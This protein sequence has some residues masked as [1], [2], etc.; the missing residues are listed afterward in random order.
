MQFISFA[1]RVLCY[2][3]LMRKLLLVPVI[4]ALLFSSV[5]EAANTGTVQTATTAGSGI[6]T[7]VS[8][9]SSPSGVVTDGT[10]IYW[11]NQASD[12][13]GRANLDGTGQNATW[14]TG[15][16]SG[17]SSL[18]TDGS[19]LY[20]VNRGS[21]NISRAAL[22]GSGLQANFISSGRGPI[23]LT[24]NS[25]HIY[26][27]RIDSRTSTAVG[28]ANLDG[29]G[30]VQSW[31]EPDGSTPISDKF[32]WAGIAAT[33]TYI[34]IGMSGRINRVAISD[35]TANY[36]F[37]TTSGYVRSVDIDSGQIYWA[38]GETG[39]IGKASQDGTGASAIVQTEPQLSGLDVYSGNIYWTSSA[40]PQYTLDIERSGPGVIAIPGGNIY[41]GTECRTSFLQGQSFSLVALPAAG[42]VFNGYSG[43]CSGISCSLT[44]GT[45]NIDIGSS[46]SYIP[47]IWKQRPAKK[48]PSPF[49][50]FRYEA[51]GADSYSCTLDRKTVPCSDRFTSG[52]LSAGRH[53]FTA[54]AIYSNQGADKKSWTWRVLKAENPDVP[55][56]TG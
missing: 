28:R 37:I 56:F 40:E 54:Q 14:L 24:I 45:S 11:S 16:F 39:I 5:A 50:T 30:A 36:G 7:L 6:S 33:D 21:W 17:P 43:A 23:S 32:G 9:Q 41:C 48:S 18:I 25:T 10:Y 8:G 46:F 26:W 3:T 1:A 52:R 51:S 35:M 49:A 55:S 31:Y 38:S 34:Y 12:S 2:I 53:T 47:L 44:F 42:A 20:W 4:L 19:Y 15:N 29:S 22:D 13:I 27:T